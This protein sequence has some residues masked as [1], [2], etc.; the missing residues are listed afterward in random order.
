MA[1]STNVSQ[2]WSRFK[3]LLDSQSSLSTILTFLDDP[4]MNVSRGRNLKELLQWL[5]SHQETYDIANLGMW[6]RKHV[7]LG[8]LSEHEIRSI[9]RLEAVTA[10][11]GKCHNWNVP[12]KVWDGLQSSSVLDAKNLETATIRSL[13][14]TSEYLSF[15]DRLSLG[16]AIINALPPL[17]L[18][19]TQ[20]ALS[21]F[22]QFIILAE[23]KLL[24]SKLKGPSYRTMLAELCGSFLGTLPKDVSL[25]CIVDTTKE[26]MKVYRRTDVSASQERGSALETWISILSR[27]K[28]FLDVRERS[29][30]RGVEY[31]MS[32]LDTNAIGAYLRHCRN[33]QI[34]H[35]ILRYWVPQD[36]QRRVWPSVTALQYRRQLNCRGQEINMDA[37]KTYLQ[38]LQTVSQNPSLFQSLLDRL[39]PLLRYLKQSEIM[40]H[41][42]RYAQ[43]SEN[44]VYINID[45][46]VWAI[47]EQSRTN[48]ILALKV[49]ASDSRALLDDCP[50]LAPS[51]VAHHKIDANSTLR[52]LLRRGQDTS[53]SYEE[54]KKK[55][56]LKPPKR[57]SILH[58]TAVAFA[59]ALHMRPRESFRG[60][61]YCYHCLLRSHSTLKPKMSQALTEA[62]VNRYLRAGQWVGSRKLRWILYLVKEI[63]GEEVAKK[64]DHI[65]YIWRD[66]VVQETSR[67]RKLEQASKHNVVLYQPICSVADIHKP[68]KISDL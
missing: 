51:V 38:T 5:V 10:E 9:L 64:L 56:I 50:G 36:I 14:K 42:I 3:H 40:L 39:I 34:E 65:V 35:F 26:L 54:R 21:S 7:S 28:L 31:S 67:Q 4:S 60:V 37:I 49:F 25:Q 20:S 53:F 18:K 15:G 47:D 43:Q 8:M 29:S 59:N 68:D 13:L 55:V 48:P 23:P 30:W 32:M 11:L 57:I 63:E 46:I 45:F 44:N 1:D 12:E 61:V 33:D 24:C 17:Q 52:F 27:S 58:D 6:I 19:Q 66:A 41:L 22:L 62:G 16:L 2:D